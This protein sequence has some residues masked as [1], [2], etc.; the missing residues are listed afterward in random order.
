MATMIIITNE[1]TRTFVDDVE[2][3]RSFFNVDVFES[4]YAPNSVQIDT[5]VSEK[6]ITHTVK[7]YGFKKVYVF[8]LSK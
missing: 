2:N 6:V 4:A 3:I 7:K 8:P 5:D 1:E